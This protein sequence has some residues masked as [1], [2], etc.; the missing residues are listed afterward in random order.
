MKLLP[1]IKH[2]MKSMSQYFHIYLVNNTAV[3]KKDKYNKQLKPNCINLFLRLRLQTK[4]CHIIDLMHREFHKDPKSPHLLFYDFSMNYYALT[5][6]IQEGKRLCTGNPEFS[7]NQ[8][9]SKRTIH[10]IHVVRIWN[11]KLFLVL[12]RGPCLLYGSRGHGRYPP[13]SGST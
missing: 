4:P 9:Q 13:A 12:A 5:K 2:H 11:P 3:M 7:T 6:F 1:D 8:P 10:I